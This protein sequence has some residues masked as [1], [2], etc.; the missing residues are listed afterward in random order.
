MDKI[1]IKVGNRPYNVKV[2]YTDEERETGLQN[3]KTLPIEQGMLFV[4]T[5]SDEVSI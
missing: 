3:V 1:K 5:E 4:F 2:A